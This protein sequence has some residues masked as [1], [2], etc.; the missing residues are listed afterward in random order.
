MSYQDLTTLEHVKQWLGISGLAIS[1]ISNASQ[2]VV[3]LVSTPPLPLVTGTVMGFSGVNGMSG[4]NGNFFPI[5]YV[6]ANSFSI[7][8]DSTSAGTYTGGGLA[9]VSDALLQRLIDAVSYF[10]QNYITRTIALQTYVETRNG[11]GQTQ[12]TT[13]NS[14]IVGVTGVTV[15]GLTIPL[16]P[17][18]TQQ[19]VSTQY[20]RSGYSFDDTRVYLDGFY[21]C[22]GNQNIVIN[23]SAGFATTP[24]DIEQ[25]AIDMIGEWF[26]YMSRIGKVAE[27]IEGQTITFSVAQIPP[28]ALAVL[29]VYNQRAPIY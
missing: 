15:N 4:L 5:T 16:R 1:S 20:G 10:I 2:A 7:P 29:N 24:P 25:A 17:P 14:P 28:R 13:K 3:T 9:G 19:S 11:L 23:Y 12:I 22:R 26:R 27:G 6:S 18:L 8:F 21:F